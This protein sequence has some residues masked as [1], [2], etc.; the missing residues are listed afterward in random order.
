MNQLRRPAAGGRST[1]TSGSGGPGAPA[2]G[3]RMAAARTGGSE[4]AAT[5]VFNCSGAPPAG[6]TAASWPGGPAGA[7]TSLAAA[8]NASMS[9]S[10][11]DGFPDWFNG[12]ASA[13]LG[14]DWLSSRE[15]GATHAE[16]KSAPAPVQTTPSTRRMG[17][18]RTGRRT[19]PP[20][21]TST[22]AVDT[23][24]RQTGIGCDES[25]KNIDMPEE[26]WKKM[27][28]AVKGSGR[29]RYKGLQNEDNLSI[30]FE[31]LHEGENEDDSDPDEVTPSA[32]PKR[33]KSQG[34]AKGKKTKTSGGQWF[35]EQMGKLV[36][37]NERTTA[38]C[39]SI[40]RG[41][42]KS[43]STIQEVMALVKGCGAKPGSN[44]HFIATV[45]F[46]KKAEREISK[47]ADNDMDD[48]GSDEDDDDC[49]IKALRVL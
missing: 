37:M 21:Q 10:L 1:H 22:L 17:G 13:A 4:S 47:T 32:R 49:K 28:N 25:G 20:V 33:G 19:R 26:W 29:F 11:G 39:E 16:E 18:G 8:G 31:D 7:A 36:E 46:T 34:N 12:T 9:G 3:A 14:S 15:I 43:G 48:S 35:Q 6:A 41:E 45:V 2:A 38:S 30:M 44:E 5:G 23:E 24:A 40:A 42:D 27:A